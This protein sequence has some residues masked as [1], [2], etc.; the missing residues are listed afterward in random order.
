MNQHRHQ[1]HESPPERKPKHGTEISDLRYENMTEAD[2]REDLSTYIIIRMD[3]SQN[4]NERDRAVVP[5]WD[6]VT[7]T[8]EIDISQEEATRKVRELNKKTDTA[9]NKKNEMPANVQRQIERARDVLETWDPDSRY[10]YELAQLESRISEIDEKSPLY[11]IHI[12]KGK[13]KDKKPKS[14]EEYRDEKG[15]NN[16]KF[17]RVS[18]TAY[19]RR[20]PKRNLDALD[21][22]QQ[23]MR[24]REQSI[25]SFGGGQ[26]IF[27][28]FSEGRSRI[29]IDLT[30]HDEALEPTNAPLIRAMVPCQMPQRATIRMMTKGQSNLL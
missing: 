8:E 17:E 12:S 24:S 11:K 19:F 16:K 28:G 5:S 20:V 15:K 14:G 1:V 2:A 9:I 27:E 10:E 29:E 23:I 7:R 25:S 3:K 26:S 13:D 30:S 4:T 18:V 6:R 21:M 22:L